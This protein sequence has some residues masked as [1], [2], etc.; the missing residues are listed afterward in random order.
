MPCSTRAK[1]VGSKKKPLLEPLP[2]GATAAADEIRAVRLSD[3]DVAL[4]LRARRSR[5]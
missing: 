3:V 4:D 1:I 5:G 2:V